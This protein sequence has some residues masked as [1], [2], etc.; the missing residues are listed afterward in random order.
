MERRADFAARYEALLGTVDALVCP[1]TT[2]P[3]PVLDGMAYE[4]TEEFGAALVS[5]GQRFDPPLVGIQQFTAPADFAGT[6]TISVPC[7]F[8]AAGAPLGLQLVGRDRSEAT[9]CRIAHAYE[10][11]TEWHRRHP[12]V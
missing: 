11:A 6:P 1:S 9:L 5:I 12:D 2:T 3:M 4:G 10:Q 7:G 8:N